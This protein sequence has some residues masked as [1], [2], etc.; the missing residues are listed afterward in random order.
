MYGEHRTTGIA[1]YHVR[2]MARSYSER[3]GT[4][5]V[6]RARERVHD[7]VKRGDSIGA[8]LW[9]RIVIA[10]KDLSRAGDSPQHSAQK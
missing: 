3:H 10:L 8:D 5:A 2:Q 6:G 4:N 7:L 9:I 1:D